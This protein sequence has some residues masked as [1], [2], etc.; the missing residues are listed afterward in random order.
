M[1]TALSIFLKGLLA[2]PELRVEVAQEV[3]R[4]SLS[5]A[6]YMKARANY[7]R[8]WG[9]VDLDMFDESWA[10]NPASGNPDLQ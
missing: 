3:G 10:C 6:A 9:E 2:T 7:I 1:S 5:D 4:T 8:L